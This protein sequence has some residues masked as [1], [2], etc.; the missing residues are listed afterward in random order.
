MAIKLGRELTPLRRSLPSGRRGH[1]R[2]R[3]TNAVGETHSGRREEPHHPRLA[4]ASGSRQW[5]HHAD[6]CWHWRQDGSEEH[7]RSM[8]SIVRETSITHWQR[9]G[10][11][12]MPST[13]FSH[14]ISISTTREDL[15]HVMP[16]ATSSRASSSTL[17]RTH[18]RVGG[19]HA[20]ARAEPRELP[21]GE[22]RS[23]D[24]RRC[25][26]SRRR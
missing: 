21:A 10:W 26:R 5:F 1:V 8:A 7:A 11:T 18:W 25:A 14:R 20:S 6:R 15:R 4:S 19:R 3:P 24:E 2:R 16:P 9:S 17:R 13:S 22:L 12:R 23:V